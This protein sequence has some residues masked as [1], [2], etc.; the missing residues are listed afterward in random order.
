MFVHELG[1]SAS[2][3]NLSVVLHDKHIFCVTV[4]KND[5]VTINVV[6]YLPFKFMLS[7]FVTKVTKS[8]HNQGTLVVYHIKKEMLVAIHCQRVIIML[9]GEFKHE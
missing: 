5:K 9:L 3:C 6:F 2:P 7:Q 8:A 1:M 4:E